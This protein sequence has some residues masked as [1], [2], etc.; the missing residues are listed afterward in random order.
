MTTTNA[1]R[2]STP[3][4]RAVAAQ[5]D[6]HR[7]VLSLEADRRDLQLAKDTVMTCAPKGSIWAA[8][9]AAAIGHLV[10]T[11]DVQIASAKKRASEPI[12]GGD[13]K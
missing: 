10:T 6:R 11:L 5:A 3:R 7:T 1:S 4:E 2:L 9:A 8:Q 12:Y 13:P